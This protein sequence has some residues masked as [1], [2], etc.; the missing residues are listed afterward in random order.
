MWSLSLCTG[1]MWVQS[2]AEG[3]VGVRDGP[4]NWATKKGFHESGL[5]Q[6]DGNSRVVLQEKRESGH[7]VMN[8]S[9]KHLSLL[10]PVWVFRTSSHMVLRRF[11][12]SLSLDPQWQWCQRLKKGFSCTVT[13]NFIC[14]ASQDLRMPHYF[15]GFL[16]DFGQAL[17]ICSMFG[18]S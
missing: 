17:L 15:R 9:C 7:K 14:C 18:V 16:F 4:S 13:E 3:K 6:G 10:L 5:L 8:P 12:Q 1:R 11:K 2:R